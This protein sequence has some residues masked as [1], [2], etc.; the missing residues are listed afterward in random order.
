MTA[1]ERS[2]AQRTNEPT[3]NREEL[4]LCP[5]CG[6]EAVST[7]GRAWCG[8]FKGECDII[9]TLD[10]DSEN[11]VPIDLWNSAYCWKII[12]SQKAEIE[13]LKKRQHHS[14]LNYDALERIIEKRDETIKRLE[15][16]NKEL[17][18]QISKNDEFWL[19]QFAVERKQLKAAL[20]EKTEYAQKLENLSITQ[21]SVLVAW[22]NVSHLD[23]FNRESD[24]KTW[25]HLRGIVL[26]RFQA[27]LEPISHTSPS[28]VTDGTEGKEES[29]GCKHES[30]WFDRT[31]APRRN[32]RDGMADICN[33]CGEEV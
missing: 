11:S 4:N 18:D 31:I 7:A 25:E 12:E 28:T 10:N 24:L 3:N 26:E 9:V 21:N 8:G 15:A 2:E 20:K 32:G 27:L 13:R 23:P 17:I 14:D 29:K 6:S 16:E 33:D 5:F 1:D 19:S 22:G 30:T